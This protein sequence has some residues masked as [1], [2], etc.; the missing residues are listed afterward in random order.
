MREFSGDECTA[1]IVKSTSRRVSPR[2]WRTGPSEAVKGRTHESDSVISWKRRR[3]SPLSSR[4][5]NFYEVPWRTDSSGSASHTDPSDLDS[6]PEEQNDKLSSRL[7]KG[8]DNFRAEL[9]SGFINCCVRSLQSTLSWRIRPAVASHAFMSSSASIVEPSARNN[10]GSRTS[11]KAPRSM[12][13]PCVNN[14]VRSAL[15]PLV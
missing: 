7:G 13:R 9:H 8:A 6:T 4:N 15:L 2:Q 5:S 12:I 11:S 14:E 1:F 3:N 10:T